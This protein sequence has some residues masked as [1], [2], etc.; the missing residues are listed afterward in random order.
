MGRDDETPIQY[1]R[2]PFGPGASWPR[3]GVGREAP[4]ALEAE[5]PIRLLIVEDRPTDAELMV[6]R[7]DE[8][9]FRVDWRRV[10]TE[11]DLRAA[12]D[13]EPDV[14]LTDWSMPR[15]SGLGALKVVRERD[16][17]LP[18][19][20]VSGSIGEETAVDAIRLGADDYLL[21]DRLVGLG[22]AVRRAMR[23]RRLR[24]DE[25]RARL[26]HERLATAIEH[27]AEAVVV[28][29]A[30]ARIIYVNP[31]CERLTGYSAEEAVGQ[32]PRLIR[33]GEHLPAFY[34][35]M[36]Q[37]LTSGRSWIAEMVNRRKDGSLFRAASTISPVLDDTGAP[38]SYVSVMRD[39]THERQL[40]VAAAR[41]ARERALIVRTLASLPVEG[42]SEATAE[43]ICRNIT[44]LASVVAVALVHFGHGTTARTLA[45][46][47]EDGRSHQSHDLPPART[48]HL[49]ERAR[50]G[51]WVERWEGWP[52]H[53]YAPLL[54][55]IGARALGDV[56]IRH[57]G[58]LIGVLIAVA[59]ERDAVEVLTDTLPA[60]AE[61]ADLSGV[62]LG[63]A[64]SDL[65]TRDR[66]RSRIEQII[67]RRAFTAVFQ[68][69]VDLETGEVVGYEALTRLDSGDPPRP[70]FDSAWA[71]GVGAEMEVAALK[72]ALED[73][74]RLPAG[75]WLNL[76]VSPRLFDADVDLAAILGPAERPV[77]LEITEHD[78]V[79]DYRAVREAVLNLGQHV[80][81]AV[82]DAG[83]GS[84]NFA[85]IVEL[86][87]DFVKI[88]IGLVRN[89][90][91]DIGRQA[92][93]VGM[94]HFA[95][96]AGCRLVAEG[97]ETQAEADTVAALGVEYGQGRLYGM[98]QRVE[99][100]LTPPPREPDP[101]APG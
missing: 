53:P 81:L 12:L 22:T 35:S 79:R 32:N 67:T 59:S 25:R 33:S 96:T 48:R 37:A 7:L 45:M 24:A 4:Q 70:L 93:V 54:G 46:V 80:R 82:D 14:V 50:A 60:L 100:W 17:D 76:N 92:L 97:I 83:A 18:V 8:E 36:W 94:R 26:E 62:L 30:D 56:P 72:A 40:E 41:S 86:R 51:P 20:I 47:T 95:R 16:P 3:G 44:S 73:A 23:A 89:I 34:D 31:A 49:R 19:I 88:D 52:D 43:A 1:Q 64:V 6:L 13:W 15:F 55:Q 77:V 11:A 101:R 71:I 75:R 42:T 39:V 27:S 57:G 2:Q 84:A 98:P 29:D 69:I 58:K 21:K 74:V 87:P 85:H 90:N 78:A 10:E 63:P 61:F 9:G 28:T 68:P 91:R 38:T 65:T 5:R 66:R 99:T